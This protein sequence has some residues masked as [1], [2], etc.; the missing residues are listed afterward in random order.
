MRL[1]D[2]ADRRA[3]RVDVAGR[4][5]YH[6][7]AEVIHHAVLAQPEGHRPLANAQALFEQPLPQRGDW[8]SS[9]KQR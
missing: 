2:A 7:L 5:V 1:P 9:T 8:R 4:A 3:P 6:L